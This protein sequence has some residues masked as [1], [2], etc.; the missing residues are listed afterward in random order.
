MPTH[1]RGAELVGYWAHPG[2]SLESAPPRMGEYSILSGVRVV[3]LSQK[4]P[5][6]DGLRNEVQLSAHLSLPS[7]ALSHSLETLTPL[8]T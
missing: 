1:P 7:L 6:L 2:D 8:Y 3:C 4:S 5:A